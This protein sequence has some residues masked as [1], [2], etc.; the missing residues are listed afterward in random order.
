PWIEPAIRNDELLAELDLRPDWRPAQYE[1]VEPANSRFGARRL[2]ARDSRGQGPRQLVH[3][4]VVEEEEGLRSHDRLTPLGD[5][6]ARVRAIEQA[7][8]VRGVRP[9]PNRHQ[10]DRSLWDRRVSEAGSPARGFE[11]ARDGQEAV[12]DFFRLEPPAVHPAEKAV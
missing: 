5:D 11:P 6:R 4:R 2:L 9:R 7:A 1:G 10:V 3:E 8:E 12:A